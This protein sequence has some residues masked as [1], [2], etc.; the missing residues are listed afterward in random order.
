MGGV[1]SGGTKHINTKSIQK[2]SKFF[3]KQKLAK[4]SEQIENNRDSNAN[5]HA[6]VKRRQG[7]TFCELPIPFSRELLP[8]TPAK[9]ATKVCLDVVC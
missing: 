7:Y 3:E 9:M 2:V 6:V 8:S 5:A 4:G 1:C